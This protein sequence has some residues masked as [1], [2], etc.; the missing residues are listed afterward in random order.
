VTSPVI[1]RV[2]E[3][4]V[5]QLSPAQARCVILHIVE[6]W[7]ETRIADAYGCSQSA[8]SQVLWGQGATR[9][10]RSSRSTSSR[11][12]MVFRDEQGKSGAVSRLSTS[13]KT[14]PVMQTIIAQAQEPEPPA[15]ATRN[16]DGWFDP[17]R[18][19]PEF[20]CA[21]ATMILLDDLVD[22][23]GRIGISELARQM[24][25][26][27]MSA[28]LPQLRAFGFI[29]NNIE[30]GVVRVLKMPASR[31]RPA[32]PTS[33]PSATHV[34]GDTTRSPEDSIIARLDAEA[35]EQP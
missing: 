4:A 12:D 6:G 21:Y 30:P 2:V 17:C 31:A 29:D 11:L 33:S 8:V 32:L 16:L 34:D 19:R 25:P 15:R 23:T 10:S 28:V 35:K 24:P 22:A 3:L 20:F 27:I 1:A 18:Y 26:A 5:T 7:T 9:A 13:I 14:D